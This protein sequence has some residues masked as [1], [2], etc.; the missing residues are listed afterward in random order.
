M[1][2]NA[3]GDASK[4]LRG[5]ET[6][7]FKRLP[8]V[9]VWRTATGPFTEVDPAFQRHPFEHSGKVVVMIDKNGDVYLADE[10]DLDECVKAVE[11]VLRL[12]QTKTRCQRD[13][14]PYTER[15]SD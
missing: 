3:K 6:G 2:D 5:V 13:G 14:I 7:T 9:K 8:V 11:Q 15:R 12:T 10:K 4:V 1:S